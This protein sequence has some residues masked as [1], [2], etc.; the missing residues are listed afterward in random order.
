MSTHTS[1]ASLL[2]AERR[3]H[4]DMIK[5]SNALRTAIHQRHPCIVFTLRARQGTIR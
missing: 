5:G 4:S 3:Q 1:E 2:N